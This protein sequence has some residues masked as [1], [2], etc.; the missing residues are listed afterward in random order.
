MRSSRRLLALA[1]LPVLALAACGDPES[2]APAESPGTTLPPVTTVAPVTT[3]DP[4][5]PVESPGDATTIPPGAPDI[6]AALRRAASLLGSYDTDLPDDVRIARRG[7]EQFALT[8]DLVPGR[9]TVEL[10]DDGTGAFV[11]TSVTV[12]TEDGSEVVTAETLLEDA[13][14]A[15]GTLETGLD[16]AWRLG[17]R[18]DESFALTD[19]FVVGRFTVELDDDGTGAFVVTAVIVELPGGAQT[20]T[21]P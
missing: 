3:I 11:V 4:D 20:V 6:G 7:E 16:P 18:G 2:T 9:L 14:Q 5:T 1:V 10:D 13:Q 12:E 17:R 19:D 21:A 8:T 15:L